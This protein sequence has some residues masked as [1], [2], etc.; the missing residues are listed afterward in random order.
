M[1]ELPAYHR[2]RRC[3]GRSIVVVVVL[4]LAIVAACDSSVDGETDDASGTTPDETP[5]EACADGECRLWQ[6]GEI[7]GIG[8]GFHIP[9][10][11]ADSVRRIALDE[12][13]LTSNH[14]V[15]WRDTWPERDQ[16]DWE[17]AEE[18]YRFA[19]ENDLDQAAYHFAWDQEFLDDLPDSGWVQ[20]V[21]DPDEL[22]E[23]L[24]IRARELFA[25]YPEIDK[26]NVIN[27]PLWTLGQS[28]DLYPNHF[29]EVLGPDYIAE[30]FEIVDAEAPDHVDLVLNENYVEYFPLKAE[31]L[32][33]LVGDLVAEDVPID[34]V[35]FQGHLMFTELLDREPDIDLLRATMQEVADLGVDVWVSELDNP[36]EPGTPDRFEY[37]ADNYRA[38]VEACLAVSRCTDILIWGVADERPLWN[39][40]LT[41]G[42]IGYEDADA[43]LFDADGKP[44]PASFAVRDALLAGRPDTGGG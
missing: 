22:R 33:D 38:V 32:V 26:I 3:A 14:A 10:D 27:E 42:F 30:L 5:E 21:T 20:E 43:L 16:P 34:S 39:H 37:Q 44:K 4:L 7:A 40:P 35:G 11:S 2:L 29:F 12:G 13:N 31:A 6:A 23:V 36:V 19:E 41:A 1:F 9:A 17:A 24:R 25:R 8:V 15:S 28:P 18:Q